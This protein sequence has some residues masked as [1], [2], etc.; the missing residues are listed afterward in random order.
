MNSIRILLRSIRTDA[1]EHGGI[2][3][4]PDHKHGGQQNYYDPKRDARSDHP[5]NGMTSVSDDDELIDYPL[6]LVL[7]KD[8]RLTWEDD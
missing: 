5:G 2:Q 7:H 8:G 4:V 6:E 3:E 1:A